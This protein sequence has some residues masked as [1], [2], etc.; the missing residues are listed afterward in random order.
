MLTTTD[1]TPAFALRLGPLERPG[2]YVASVAG[3]S[4]A[5]AV[6]IDAGESDLR[7]MSEDSL[8]AAL[9]RDVTYVDVAELRRDSAA[10]RLGS[11]LRPFTAATEIAGGLLLAVLALLLIECW[12]AARFGRSR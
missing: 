7:G 2:A 3:R 4:T 8:R 9:D 6:N 10:G 1:G 5:Y 11:A 12:L